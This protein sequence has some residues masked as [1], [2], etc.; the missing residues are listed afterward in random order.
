MV[1]PLFMTA[2]HPI[3]RTMAVVIDCAAHICCVNWLLSSTH[4]TTP[5][6]AIWNACYRKPANRPPRVLKNVWAI[7]RSSIYKNVIGIFWRVPKM[8]CQ[9]FHP[10]PAVSAANL[11]NLM[12]TIFGKDWKF[13][14]QRYCCS[15]KIPMCRLPITEQN[16]TWEYQRSSKRSQVVSE[17]ANMHMPIA[18]FQAI[19][20]PWPTRGIT[21]MAL[22]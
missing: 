15:L 3:Y 22:T 14:K 20:S 6:R 2:D 8:N 1:A 19:C 9:S 11:P 10:N 17:P 13:M 16:A 12:R 18:V 7:K 21:R 5:G 4:M